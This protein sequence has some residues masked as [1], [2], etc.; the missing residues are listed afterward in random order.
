MK[1]AWQAQGSLDLSV[2][3]LKQIDLSISELEHIAA[4]GAGDFVASVSAG[5]AFSGLVLA[6]IAIT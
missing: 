2:N 3:E 1:D 4:P 6:G 5:L